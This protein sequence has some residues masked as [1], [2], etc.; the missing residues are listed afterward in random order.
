LFAQDR[1][2]SIRGYVQ[3][4]SLGAVKSAQVS[5]RNLE[6]GR[7][8]VT[9]TDSFG[10]YLVSPLDIGRYSVSV[11]KGG[12]KTS[13]HSGVVLTVDRTAELRHTLEV[14]DASQ[15]VT[16]EGAAI[17][18]EATPSAISS[19]IGGRVISDLP[20]NGRD[21]V[22]LATLDAGVPV[23]RGRQRTVFNGY[24]VP[25]SIAGGRPMQNN[26]RLD[27]VSITT[28]NGSTPGSINGVNL[29][30]EAVA[31]FSVLSS[32]FGAQYGR[33]SGGVINAATRS[34]TNEFHGSVF[35]FHRNDQLDARNYFDPAEKPEYRR[36]QYGGALGGP[37]QANRSF[38]FVNYEG[39]RDVRGRTTIDTT[40][41]D[42]ARNGMIQGGAVRIDPRISPVVALYPRPNG[43]VLGDTGL[44]TYAN[45]QSGNEGFVTA[46]LDHNLSQSD[47][48]FARYSF[49][50]GDRTE[51]T[52]F[53]LGRRLN[54][55]RYHSLAVEETH[56]FSASLLNVVRFGFLR[57]DTAA[58]RTETLT[59]G[60]DD[61][62]LAFIP[63]SP[64]MGTI[65]VGGLTLFPGGSG[66]ENVNQ[67][68]LSSYQFS[69]DVTWQ[70]AGVSIR[71]GARIERT[72]YELD[73]QVEPRGTYRF[74]NVRSFLTNVA[75]RFRA[76]L[77]GSDTVRDHGQWIPAW[78]L[79]ATWK[80]HRRVTLDAGIRHEWA[81]TPVE[82]NGKTANLDQLTD[83]AP[84]IGDPMFDA[85]SARMIYPRAG[86]AIDVFG[87]GSTVIRGGYGIYAELLLSPYIMR[88]SVRNPPFFLRGSTRD[89]RQGDFPQGGWDILVNSNSAEQTAER[90]PRDLR[91]PYVQQWNF[92]LDQRLG[93]STSARISYLGSH[94]IR[95]SSVTDDAN[96]VTPV[97]L[98]DGRLFFPA[99]G[100]R[101]NGLY[102][103]VRNRAFDAQS[104]YHGMHARVER[105]FSRGLGAQASY[106]FSKSMDESS[107]YLSTSEAANSAFL[108]IA[109]SARLNRGL[110]G[111][112][113]RH[114]LVLHGTWEIPSPAAGTPKAILG[115]W[116]LGAIVTATSGLPT[117]A[118]LGYD[119]ARTRTNST[120]ADTGQRPDLV[121]GV[122][123]HTGDAGQWITSAAFSRPAAGFLGNVARNTITGP[124]LR[125]FDLSVVKTVP[126]SRLR[127]GSAIDFRFEFFNLTNHTNFHLPTR[128]RMEVFTATATREDVGRITS[129]ADSRQIQLGAR[130]RF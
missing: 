39:L 53:A 17:L 106:V 104:Y 32:T 110:S 64:A 109:G 66:A 82:A 65:D 79:Q 19:I 102:S 116:R 92:N 49:D 42:D 129:A 86:F 7:V 123:P 31:E 8:S 114:S 51:K 22:Q 37:I 1:T 12:F 15:S 11:E 70:R 46:R 105:R 20:L 90:I 44:F 95:L 117:T 94:G 85:R 2:S 56:A 68:V 61:S 57:T 5:A 4:S 34:G 125:N 119:G 6:T 122:N 96:T 26:F 52:A 59:P 111:H 43:E 14:G 16:V 36:H 121:L 30:A 25:I 50:A 124:D 24:G 67:H 127:E 48:L 73:S 87:S 91:Q 29:G 54:D 130:I 81:T 60:T 10:N 62:R 13:V 97:T 84:R 113:V 101:I 83:T 9:R 80:A 38:F 18:A 28:Y 40:L 112:D 99:N 128:D 41:S 58:G 35:Y 93:R 74:R 76:Q 63:G 118:W 21:Y 126:L 71:A 55:S 23:A 89:L 69:N 100:Q 107:D 47:K 120:G 27:G 3:D 103:A 108:P 88:F 45:D 98:G 75:D 72:R 77:P 78:Y 115:G 33:A